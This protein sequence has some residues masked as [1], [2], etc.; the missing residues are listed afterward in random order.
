[1][2]PLNQQQANALHRLSQHDDFAVFS[3]LMSEMDAISQSV[4]MVNEHEVELRRQQ[5]E[6]RRHRKLLALLDEAERVV[7]GS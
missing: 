6:C 4:L 3:Q 5:G 7:R 1:M 2:F